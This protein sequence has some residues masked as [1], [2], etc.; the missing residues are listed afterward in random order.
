MSPPYYGALFVGNVVSLPIPP[1]LRCDEYILTR[2][3]LYQNQKGGKTITIKLV[4]D[5]LSVGQLR[6]P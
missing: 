3:A 2:V 4:S 5:P 6:L 1:Q